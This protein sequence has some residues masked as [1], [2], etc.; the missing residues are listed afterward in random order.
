[1]IHV[2]Y[3][4]IP[5]HFSLFGLGFLCRAHVKCGLLFQC[6]FHRINKDEF[7]VTMILLQL[8][9][10]DIY[11]HKHVENVAKVAIAYC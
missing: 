2:Q 6:R 8:E 5:T 4:L 11:T 1:M 3:G 10:H 7:M 9:H